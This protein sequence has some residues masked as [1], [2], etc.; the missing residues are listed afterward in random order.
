MKKFKRFLAAITTVA[1][2]AVSFCSMFT[3]SAD[4]TQLKTFRIFHEVAV[5]SNIA[6]FDYTINYSS[7]VTATPSIKTNLLDNGYFTS[8]NNG[9]VQA[10]Y[11]GNSINTNG[12]IATTDFY[13]PMS[14]TSIFNEISYNA[15]IRNSNN[16]N[17]DPNSITMTSV[18][19][20][21]VNQD[22]CVSAADV[23]ALDKY[24]FNSDLYPLPE[25]WLLAADV[26]YDSI[27]NIEDVNKITDYI[28]GVVDYL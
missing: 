24:L 23:N 2:S 20:G 1:V 26:K 4:T 27:I 9:K 22:G 8:T 11:L 12:I 25:K 17:I 14:V 28:M 18:L 15:T 10:T 5:N 19:M 21:D 3:A 13:T 6:Y 16:N 7:I